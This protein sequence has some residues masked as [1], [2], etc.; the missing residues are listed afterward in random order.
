MMEGEK[1]KVQNPV[2]DLD[3]DEMTRVIWTM[4]KDKVREIWPRVSRLDFRQACSEH[5]RER[6]GP[7][8]PV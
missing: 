8:P 1:I 2:V 7:A 4:I 3:G 6:G 5:V